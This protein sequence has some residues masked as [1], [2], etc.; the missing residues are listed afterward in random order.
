MSFP[1]GYTKYQE[2]TIDSSKVTA[3]QTDFPI[4][5]DLSEMLKAGADIFDSCRADGGDIRVTKADG[6]TQLPREVVAIDTGAKTGELHI[7][8][9]GTLSSSSPTVIRIYYNGTDTE[10]AANSTYGSQNVWSD[11]LAV[12][13]FNSSNANSTSGSFSGSDTSMSYGGSYGKLGGGALFNGYSSIISFASTMIPTGG[14][15]WSLTMWANQNTLTSGHQEFFSQWTY[16]TS[17]NA[18][19]LGT[20]A[21]TKIRMSDAWNYDLTSN[22]TADTWRY[23]ANIN[24]ATN[25]HL[26]TNAVLR[27]SK[28]SA[29]TFSGTGN[30]MFGRQ[31]EYAN[32][33]FDGFLDEARI[34]L[35]TL[36]GDW[37]TTEYNNQSSPS[38][39]Y[40][41]SEEQGEA[42]GRSFAQ[43]I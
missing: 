17:G 12:F 43:I 26:Y 3:D 20:S 9:T 39:F 34:R 5:I 19:F 11:Y 16:P 24:E 42:V 15:P 41:V 37:L 4:Y 38:T 1:T 32:E 18:Y 30:A 21:N 2:V 22:W 13:H 40:S 8:Y 31:G 29:M 27:A 10:P 36:S 23:V 14:N 25:N 6:T 28:G 7:K 35:S 33:Y